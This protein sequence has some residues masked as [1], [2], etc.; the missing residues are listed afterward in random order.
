MT[1]MCLCTHRKT[2]GR[3]CRGTEMHRA[4]KSNSPELASKRMVLPKVERLQSR[5]TVNQQSSVALSGNVGTAAEMCPGLYSRR[6]LFLRIRTL[7][8]TRNKLA[9]EQNRL[10]AWETYRSNI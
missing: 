4:R 2:G 1:R 5:R 7:M 9:A 8:P 3:G 6:E 10:T